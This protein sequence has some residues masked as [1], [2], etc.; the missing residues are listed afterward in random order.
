MVYIPGSNNGTW[1]A[2]MHRAMFPASLGGSLG[3]RGQ[4]LPNAFPHPTGINYNKRSF[5]VYIK[6]RRRKRNS[7]KS[8]KSYKR[9]KSVRRQRSQRRR[10]SRR[11]GGT[12]YQLTPGGV[13][14]SEGWGFVPY[15]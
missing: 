2:G 9:R 10:Y 7:E 12:V 1:G 15:F 3:H 4:P 14:T 8:R 6:R 5:G 13:T 11:F